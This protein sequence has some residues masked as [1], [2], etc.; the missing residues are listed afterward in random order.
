LHY[1]A[2]PGL[3]KTMIIALA[4]RNVKAALSAILVRYKRSAIPAG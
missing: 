2:E 1:H 4:R 3:R